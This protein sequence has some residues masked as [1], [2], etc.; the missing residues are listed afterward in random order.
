MKWGLARGRTSCHRFLPNQ[1]RRRL[2]A[3]AGVLLGLLQEA[4]AGTRFA[5]AP[6]SMLRLRLLKVGARVVKTARRICFHLPS[7]F[8]DKDLWPPLHPKLLAVFTG[9]NRECL[10]H[11]RRSAVGRPS[12]RGGHAWGARPR[13]SPPLGKDK[14]R[15]I[16]RQRLRLALQN[17]GL[18]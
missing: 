18:S 6:V 11:P 7:A 2:H 8:P 17:S 13:R 3:G 5:K 14:S 1:F 12:R 9:H 4:L 10:N 16:Q 15:A